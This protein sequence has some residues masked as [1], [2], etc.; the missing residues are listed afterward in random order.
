MTNKRRRAQISARK[1]VSLI[2]GMKII[3]RLSNRSATTCKAH[4]ALFILRGNKK[5]IIRLIRKPDYIKLITSSYT[6][7]S[8]LPFTA[9]PAIDLIFLASRTQPLNMDSVNARRNS[10]NI[11]FPNLKKRRTVR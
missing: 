11:Y 4:A 7:K 9:H 10:A 3:D 1:N 6:A 2:L 8:K 5:L